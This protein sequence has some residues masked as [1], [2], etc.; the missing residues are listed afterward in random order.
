MRVLIAVDGTAGGY[1]AVEYAGRLLEGNVDPVFLYYAPPHVSLKESG[2][3]E[4]ETARR[5]EQALVDAVFDRAKEK[6]PL[7]FHD[8]VVTIVGTQKA[9]HG[10]L[11]AADE[12]RVD[13]IVVG[14]HGIRPLEWLRVGSVSR[15]VAS[16]ATTPVLV[17]RPSDARPS[18]GPFRVLV[19]YDRTDSGRGPK[20]FIQYF[21]W[22]HDTR[23]EV[24][25]VFES[26]M[27]EVPE[28]LQETMARESGL[29]VGVPFEPFAA[30]KQRAQQRVDEWCRDLPA[31]FRK[32][33]G[34]VVEGH[35]ARAILEQLKSQPY[36][37]VILGARHQRALERWLLGSTSYTVLNQAPCSVLIVRE[38]EKP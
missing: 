19:A 34:R 2:P 3:I 11:V 27:A 29:P 21:A 13:L 18:D 17:V 8:S 38:H 10:I 15:A 35:A 23:G 30:D 31:S 20:S 7:R 37:L 5:V 36:D 28:W 22:P 1:T 25:S 4:D 32:Q 6:L 9:R 14:S 24:L 16:A 33:P 26:Y 12:N